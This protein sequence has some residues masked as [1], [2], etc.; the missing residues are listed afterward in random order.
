MH[1]TAK[2]TTGETKM[3]CSNYFEQGVKAA[4]AGKLHS[5]N[6]YTYDPLWDNLDA[7]VARQ[8]WARGYNK[9]KFAVA[10]GAKHLLQAV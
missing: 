5:E 3:T 4:I 2:A 9:V 7:F 10:R 8:E 6:P 1:G